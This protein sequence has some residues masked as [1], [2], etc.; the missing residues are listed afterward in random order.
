M[1][2]VTVP[3]SDVTLDEVS[4][5]LRAK[6]GPRYNIRPSMRSTGFGKE[7]PGDARMM[8]VAANWLERANVRVVPGVGSTAIQVD[9]GATYFGLIR[10]IHHLGVA[11]KVRQALADAPELA[12]PN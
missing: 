10:L 6:L 5:A 4:A 11:R 12:R 8:L 2:T 9:A 1:F 3:R 7:V